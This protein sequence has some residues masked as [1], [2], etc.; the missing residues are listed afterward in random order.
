M[1]VQTD[2]VSHIRQLRVL[3]D[4]EEFPKVSEFAEQCLDA[5]GCVARAK[6]QMLVAV[7]EIFVNIA[8]YG[9]PDGPMEVS[10]DFRLEA[11]DPPLACIC[12]S[13]T[14]IPFDP[15]SRPDPDVTLSAEERGIGGLGIYM[16]KQSMDAVSYEYLDGKNVVTVKRAIRDSISENENK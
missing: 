6:I 3:A 8:Q 10:I 14:G 1:E 16:V 15:F 13:D 9:Y 2:P 12:F 11:G 5:C 4:V 7:E